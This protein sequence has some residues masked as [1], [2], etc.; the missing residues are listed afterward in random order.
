M[1]GKTNVKEARIQ[2]VPSQA[3][4]F[5]KLRTW[6]IFFVVG[7]HTSPVSELRSGLPNHPISK[8]AAK[9]AALQAVRRHPPEA[10]KNDESPHAASTPVQ[11]N[12]DSVARLPLYRDRLAHSAM[13]VAGLDRLGARNEYF[14]PNVGTV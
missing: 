3:A 14:V 5:P 10:F 8:M 12:R 9:V 1:P 4:T 7:S 6:W 13:Q 2:I 11:R